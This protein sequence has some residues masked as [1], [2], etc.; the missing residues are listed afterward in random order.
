MRKGFGP[1][2]IVL[3]ALFAIG[4]YEQIQSGSRM[5]LIPVALVL[6]VFILYKFPPD[7]LFGRGRGRSSER[8][9]YRQAAA[10][11]K[12]RQSVRQETSTKRKAASPF[13][14][15]EGNKKNDDEPPTYH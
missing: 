10:A 7:R 15:I 12:R 4:L 8:A 5:L 14:V 9:K 11:S 2:A 3:F 13:R 6:L 1:V